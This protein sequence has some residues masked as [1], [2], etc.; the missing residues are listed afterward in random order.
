MKPPPNDRR[1][2]FVPALAGVILLAAIAGLAIWF[3][4]EAMPL[5]RNLIAA[6]P[7]EI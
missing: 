5:G 3:A 6:T 1:R 7:E 4:A 2:R